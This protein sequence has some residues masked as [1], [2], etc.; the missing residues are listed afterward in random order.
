[1]RIPS[2]IAA[3]FFVASH[4]VTATEPVTAIV[5]HGGA[6][7]ILKQ[8]ITPA[9]RLAYH[10][11]LKQAVRAGHNVL[12]DGGTSEDAV[13]AAIMIMEDS[14]LFNAGH[15]AVLNHLGEAEL[16]A[17]IMRGD[18]RNA[19]AVAGVKSVKN[20]ILAA[21]E[22]MH[23]SPHVFMAGNGAETF[24][25]ERQ[26]PLVD[27]AYFITERRQ[28]QLMRIQAE[29]RKTLDDRAGT[30][31]AVAL[32]RFGNITA[33]TSTGGMSNKRYGRI[34]DVPVIGAGTYADN[35]TCGISATGHGEYF[36]RAAVAFNICS[37]S[38]LL[39]LSLQDAA[40][41]VMHQELVEMGGDGGVVGLAPNGDVV[42]S[43]NSEG[44]YR[45]YIDA[46][47]NEYSAIFKDD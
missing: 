43:F 16:D 8:D 28:Q 17:S 20:P 22:V 36:I 45:A 46:N 34:G 31:G 29:E 39:N 19:G 7:T 25:T 35:R 2:I 3:M 11:A 44:M 9:Q 13:V 21:R 4:H 27:N 23:H 6:G 14:P 38:R 1:M 5:V 32:D 37:Q 12:K 41:N 47:G 30:V 15:G 24:A 18:D 10:D 42:M 40:D 26:L 33:A